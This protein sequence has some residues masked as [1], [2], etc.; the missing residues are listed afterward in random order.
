MHSL[1]TASPAVESRSCLIAQEVLRQVSYGF[2]VLF[3]LDFRFYRRCTARQIQRLTSP[4]DAFK[5]V[6]VLDIYLLDFLKSRR[7]K[8]RF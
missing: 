6:V 8:I 4:I 2:R 1:Q 7:D 5:V 3:Q